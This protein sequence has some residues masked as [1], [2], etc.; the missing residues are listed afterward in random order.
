MECRIGCCLN[1]LLDKIKEMWKRT[2]SI[3]FNYHFWNEDYCDFIFSNCITNW[4]NIKGKV[5][6]KKRKPDP[7]WILNVS[8]AYGLQL[9]CFSVDSFL[10]YFCHSELL[11]SSQMNF[12]DFIMPLCNYSCHNVV[13]Q[14]ACPWVFP[15]LGIQVTWACWCFKRKIYHYYI[16]KL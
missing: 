10:N 2:V 4:E 3:I 13:P 1:T 5:R 8:P 16:G 7:L 15:C 9:G 14:E 11:I 12:P 6:E